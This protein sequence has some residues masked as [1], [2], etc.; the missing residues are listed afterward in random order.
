LDEQHAKKPNVR[1]LMEQPWQ[2]T[3]AEL[4]DVLVDNLLHLDFMIK[5]SAKLTATVITILMML[6]KLIP[7]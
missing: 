3:K 2:Q 1:R 6:W 7:E 5:A 4:W